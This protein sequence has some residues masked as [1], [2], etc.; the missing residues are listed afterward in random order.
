M[1]T[2]RDAPFG[3]VCRLLSRWRLFPYPEEV[4]PDYV[5]ECLETQREAEE[6]ETIGRAADPIIGSGENYGAYTLT[7]QISH[8]RST[9]ADSDDST[10]ST[11]TAAEDLEKNKKIQI[12]GWA[13]PDDPQ[14]RFSWTTLLFAIS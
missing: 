6:K 8:A 13:G 10:S 3:Q 12:V 7:F 4:Y 9:A 14:V 11:K 2:L 1:E 5:E